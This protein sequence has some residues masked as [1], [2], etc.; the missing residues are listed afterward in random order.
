MNLSPTIAPLHA[1]RLCVRAIAHTPLRIRLALAKRRYA[2][3][4]NGYISEGKGYGLVVIEG[5]RVRR[6]EYR[7]GIN[8]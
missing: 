7:L 3:A 4:W 1:L 8:A 2:R 5:S 6:L